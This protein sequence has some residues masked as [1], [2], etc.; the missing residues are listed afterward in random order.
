MV[1]NI[2]H[3]TK[4]YRLLSLP[5]R[6]ASVVSWWDMLALL[7]AGGGELACESGVLVGVGVGVLTSLR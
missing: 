7:S 4:Q 3:G 6:Y 1:T 5:R 2:G